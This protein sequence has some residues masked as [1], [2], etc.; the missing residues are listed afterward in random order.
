MIY[1]FLCIGFFDLPFDLFTFTSSPWLHWSSECPSSGF[2]V[3]CPSCCA[4]WLAALLSSV[5]QL[6][7]LGLLY[8]YIKAWSTAQPQHTGYKYDINL[9]PLSLWGLHPIGPSYP[10]PWANTLQETQ[11]QPPLVVSGRAL[12]VT[13]YINARRCEWIW[14]PVSY[15][16]W[17]LIHCV[18]LLAP[19]SRFTFFTCQPEEHFL[20]VPVGEINSSVRILS[21]FSNCILQQPSS[22]MK[23]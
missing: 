21:F 13:C 8:N 16:Y 23:T 15:F 20:W 18:D 17:S 2:V 6:F 19:G 11:D 5:G 14:T 12:S 3:C 22:L 1:L 7:G 9:S 10:C 4:G